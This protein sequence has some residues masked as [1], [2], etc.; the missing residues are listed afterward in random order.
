MILINLLFWFINQSEYYLFCYQYLM[1]PL[2][3]LFL[4]PK[5]VQPI[6]MIIQS[7][8]LCS[9]PFLR[10]TLYLLCS[11]FLSDTQYSHYYSIVY[12]LLIWTLIKSLPM[13]YP[14]YHLILYEH[15]QYSYQLNSYYFL[16]IDLCLPLSTLYS[17]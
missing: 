9:S 2:A 8:H 12:L 16:S 3:S 7:I 1:N 13:I 17:V 10:N 11:P 15:S 4:F 6:F 14:F 5:C